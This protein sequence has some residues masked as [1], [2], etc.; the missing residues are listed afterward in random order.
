MVK[1]NYLG[2]MKNLFMK[3]FLETDRYNKIN[4]LEIFGINYWIIIC[5][6]KKMRRQIKKNILKSM[7]YKREF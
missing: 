4:N 3:E 6:H 7:K 1:G 5:L 2:I